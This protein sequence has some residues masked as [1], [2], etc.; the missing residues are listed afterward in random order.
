MSEAISRE[1]HLDLALQRLSFPTPPDEDEDVE[2]TPTTKFPAGSSRRSGML[3]SIS[4]QIVRPKSAAP[5][6]LPPQLPPDTSSFVDMLQGHLESVRNLKENTG[7]RGAKF[8][9][10]SPLSTPTKQQAR[11]WRPSDLSDDQKEALH[12]RRREM[13]WRPRFDPRSIRKLCDDA[14]DEI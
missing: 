13:V 11:S 12:K 4:T 14:L 5:P 10:P 3:I 8:G 7:V 2:P 6:Q 9:I 1:Q